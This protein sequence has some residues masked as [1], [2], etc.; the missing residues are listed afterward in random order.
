MIKLA[1]L[2]GFAV[3]GSVASAQTLLLYTNFNDTSSVGAFLSSSTN[4]VSGNYTVA[5]ATPAGTLTSP[6]N[7]NYGSFAGTTINARGGAVSGGSFVVVGSAAN[8]ST[9]TMQFNATGWED[10]VLMAAMRNTATGFTDIDVDLSTDGGGSWTSLISNV[11]PLTTTFALNV[12]SGLGV[13]ADN[14][15]DVRVRWT[16]NGATNTSGNMRLDN[17]TIEGN[18]VVPEP[19]TMAVLGL[20]VAALARRRR[21]S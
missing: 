6:A 19:A 14:Q 9:L 7:G 8:T 18:Q 12:N 5:G 2:A 13:A 4:L 3:I 11:S 16:F 15:G 10:L 1:T 20:G 17:I 21:R